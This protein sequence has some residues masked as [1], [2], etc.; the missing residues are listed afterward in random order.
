MNEHRK[1]IKAQYEKPEAEVTAFDAEDIIRTSD[2]PLP[3]GST[4]KNSGSSLFNLF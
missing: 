2:T 4:P 1:K 3:W